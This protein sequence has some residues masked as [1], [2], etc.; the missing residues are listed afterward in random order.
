MFDCVF[1]TRTARF[2]HALVDEGS[3]NLKT[4]EYEFDFTPLDTECQ[5]MVCRNYTRA[6]SK[7]LIIE[8]NSTALIE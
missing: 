7:H 3:L 4:S 5:C 6:Y 1:P 2:G 8:F